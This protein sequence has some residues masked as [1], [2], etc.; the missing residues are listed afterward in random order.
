MLIRFKTDKPD[1]QI[2]TKQYRE[3]DLNQI[4]FEKTNKILVL[5]TLIFEEET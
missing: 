1:Q 2:Y 5:V 4:T 3:E